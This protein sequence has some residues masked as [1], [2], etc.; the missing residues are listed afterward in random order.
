[1]IFLRDVKSVFN[2]KN[3]FFG[4]ALGVIS[5][6]VPQYGI[7][8]AAFFFLISSVFLLFANRL[9]KFWEAHF[10]DTINMSDSFTAVLRDK[11]GNV[12]EARKS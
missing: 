5:L 7:Y 4:L 12:K 2:K 1:M 9:Q 11:D 8:L 3:V 10:N 6:L